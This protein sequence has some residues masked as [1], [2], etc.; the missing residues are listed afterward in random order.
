MHAS[1]GLQGFL[2]QTVITTV[3]VS[4]DSKNGT[5][6]TYYLQIDPNLYFSNDPTKNTLVSITAQY[7]GIKME[8]SDQLMRPH[9][10][11]PVF[12]PFMLGANQMDTSLIIHT[13]SNI[14]SSILENCSYYNGSYGIL[15]IQVR[16]VSPSLYQLGEHV[17]LVSGELMPTMMPEIHILGQLQL[18]VRPDTCE[19][20]SAF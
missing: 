12:V 8:G 16:L 10:V 15:P 4:S 9:D 20:N 1:S 11:Q 19:F 3:N 6:Y 17:I 2:N 5:I 13:L 18:V 7:V 14:E